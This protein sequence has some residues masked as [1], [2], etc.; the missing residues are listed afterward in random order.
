MAAEAPGNARRCAEPV[1]MIDTRGAGDPIA[2]RSRCLRRR[3]TEIPMT[4]GPAVRQPTRRD[5]AALAERISG[6]WRAFRAEPGA[7]GAPPAPEV[8]RRLSSLSARLEFVETALEELQDA[9]YRQSQREDE[10]HADMRERTDPARLAR[11]LSAD[12]RRRGL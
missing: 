3:A 1:T 8:E 12:A 9:L 11:D 2:V 4:G 7:A 10:R 5:V 6:A